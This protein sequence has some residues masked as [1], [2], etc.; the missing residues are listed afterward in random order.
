MTSESKI[1]IRVHSWFLEKLY[2][3]K[4]KLSVSSGNKSGDSILD[5]VNSVFLKLRAYK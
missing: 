1:V 4:G 3:P 5:G 2:L